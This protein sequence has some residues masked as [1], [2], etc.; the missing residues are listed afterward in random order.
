MASAAINQQ[1]RP[2]VHSLLKYVYFEWARRVWSWTIEDSERERASAK[3]H[4]EILD[5]NAY[6]VYRRWSCIIQQFNHASKRITSVVI[7]I[8]GAET[9][10]AVSRIIMANSDTTKQFRRRCCLRH[11]NGSRTENIC[12]CITSQCQMACYVTELVTIIGV[13]ALPLPG[14]SSDLSSI[15]NV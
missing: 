7:Y 15:K 14:N 9:L 8:C 3:S 4:S 12:S 10:H 5:N 1:K 2:S 11:E 6:H 13:K